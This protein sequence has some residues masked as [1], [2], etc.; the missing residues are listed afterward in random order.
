MTCENHIFVANVAVIDPTRN[1][2]T[3]SVINQPTNVA[4]ELSAIAKICN[5]R[6]FHEG[7]HFILMA[8]E[9]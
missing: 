2:M 8:M 5:Y 9:V 1:T 3:M 7:H 4:M 6:R